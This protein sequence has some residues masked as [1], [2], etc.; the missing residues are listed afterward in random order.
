M[1][2]PK[3]IAFIMDGNRR[4]ARQNKLSLVQGHFRGANNIER[5]VEYASTQGVMY[6]TFYAF[7]T[8]NWKRSE[9]EVEALMKV[10][11]EMLDSDM[12]NRMMENG[13]RIQTI[14]DI[15]KF[16]DD[17]YEKLVS[18]IEQSKKNNKITAVFALNYGGRDEIVRA[19]NKILSAKQSKVSEKEFETFLFTRDI[20][21]PDLLI[22]TGGEMRLSNFLTWQSVYTELYFTQ[23]LWPD[24]LEDDLKFALEEYSVRE[25]RFGK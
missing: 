13:V 2:T 7:S 3:H 5:L 18:L 22:R 6:L 15:S 17:I 25:R 12:M 19:L 9:N 21:D 10:F 16:P 23:T 11:R 20:P 4:W 1:N 24:F 8:E 14:G